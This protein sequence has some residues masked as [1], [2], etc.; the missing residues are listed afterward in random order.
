MGMILSFWVLRKIESIKPIAFNKKT[1]NAGK[2]T[3]LN[4]TRSKTH[5]L[6]LSG[7]PTK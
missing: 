2:N 7:N 3:I 6:M 4:A 1:V 5:N